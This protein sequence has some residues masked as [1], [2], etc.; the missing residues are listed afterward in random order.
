MNT[1][2][3]D[4][5]YAFRQLRKAP[6]FTAVAVLTLALGIGA[7]TAI[8]SV[9]DAV[10]LRPLPFKDPGRVVA[11]KTTEPD[12][13]DDI[14]VSY[15][16]FLDWRSR[17]HVFEGISA[18]RTDDFTLTGNGEPAHLRGAIVSAN[19]P[20]LL[21]VLPMLGRSFLPAED[22]PEAGLPILLGDRFWRDRF[23]SDRKILGQSLTLSGQ[24]FTVVGVMPATFQFPVQRDQIDFWTTVALDARSANGNPP[25]TAQRGISYLD[26]IARLKPQ[27]TDA[28]AQSEMAQIQD[29]LNKEYP[30]NRPKGVS[31][32]RE[33]DDV[34][35]DSR[36][37]LLILF[38]AVGLVLLIACANLSN[39][40]L[41]RATERSGEVS[42][43]LAL[44]A[45]RWAIVRQL[46]TENMVLAVVGAALGMAVASWSLRFL[47]NLAPSDLPRITETSLNGS[48][49][50]FTAALLLL[51]CLFFGLL[52]ALQACKPQV[53]SA[54]NE[55]GRSGTETRA[56]GRL[57]SAF[58]V[59]QTA[60]AVLLLIAAGLLLRS[61]L[62][63]G[64]VDPGFAK[65]HAIT[66]GLDLPDRYGHAERVG[67]YRR[68]LDGLR[69]VPGVRAASAGFPL[70]TLAADVKTSFD[71]EGRP[72][73][74]SE[75]TAT[76]LHI[77]D[78]DYF[79]TL[80]IP[81]VAGRAFDAHDESST[82]LP[83]AIISQSLAQRAFPGQDPVG[84]RIQLD[85]SSGP[86]QAP[87]R[88][89]VGV[90]GDVKGEGLG[91]PTVLESY[92]PYAQLPFAPM[93]V[94]VRTEMPPQN[95]VPTL[96]RVVQ[97]IDKDLPLLH[98]K[99]LDE[100][101]SDSVAGSRFQAVLL[102]IFG[103]F[104]L[105]LTSLGLYGVIAYTVSR[106]RREMGI[107]FALGANPR[108]ILLIVV[109]HGM[110]LAAVGIA[111]GA[112]TAL[113]LTRL[114][115]SLLYRVKPTD[116]ATFVAVPILLAGIA[117]LATYIPA[118]RA[119]KVDLNVALRCE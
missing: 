18:F 59:S 105:V 32:A 100:Y 72:M 38:G 48:V 91:A 62:E 13:R 24:V 17:N 11:V 85:I 50:G 7:N 42:I 73:K 89:I 61:L 5:R 63:L 10:L 79:R 3:Q 115:T 82:A 19:L 108:S 12:R 96:A 74:A 102:A 45:S 54:L 107:R 1:I 84:R 66:F 94:V 23:G 55:G 35:G 106:R 20:S 22:H 57:K 114:I 60:L 27:I 93:S 53:A 49:L 39:L 109:K 118:R 117:L 88:L 70:P 80:G 113:L 9:I 16:A 110:R 86:Q 21:G 56:Q 43:R 83:S 67:F 81:I 90:A 52:P 95:L 41:V 30:E 78:Q 65:D 87:M 77:V 28:Q 29:G 51:S 75:R 68:L 34:V 103:G 46:I 2:L 64:K 33:I 111:I 36:S 104:A 44:G 8:F 25:M 40:L 71:I 4:L 69:G 14:G 119:S 37:G 15:P 6:G 98:V 31:V 47:V 99:S 92:V 112:M 26:V 76:T 58:V 101:V 116:P 97:S